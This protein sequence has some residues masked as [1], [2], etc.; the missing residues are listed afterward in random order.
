MKFIVLFLVV[1]VGFVSNQHDHGSMSSGSQFSNFQ[2]CI[3][4]KNVGR[5]EWSLLHNSTILNL[6]MTYNFAGM[7][8]GGIG[9]NDIDIFPKMK[10]ASIYI[11]SGSCDINGCDLYNYRGNSQNNSRPDP[12]PRMSSLINGY[13][14][15]EG[16]TLYLNIN[17]N[18]TDPTFIISNRTIS[19]LFAYHNVSLFL[20]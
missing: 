15:N 16:Q 11:G 7:G 6:R 13:V 9:F 1:L 10:L 12:L 3:P 19:I 17:R 8:W 20:S 2:N 4:I 14:S 18:L 5:L